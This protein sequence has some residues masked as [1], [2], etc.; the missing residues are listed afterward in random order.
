MAVLRYQPAAN[1]KTHAALLGPAGKK[2]HTDAGDD[3][4]YYIAQTPPIHC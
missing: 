3:V 2:Q 4:R 1:N